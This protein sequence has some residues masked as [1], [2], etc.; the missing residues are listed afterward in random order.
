MVKEED[1]TIQK[2]RGSLSTAMTLVTGAGMAAAHSEIMTIGAGMAGGE[3]MII[4]A[5]TGG[6]EIMTIGVTLS[7]GLVIIA[8]GP[9]TIGTVTLRHADSIAPGTKAKQIIADCGLPICDCPVAARSKI[10]SLQSAMALPTRRE[11]N[12]SRL[13]SALVRPLMTPLNYS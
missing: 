7:I 11:E 12:A 8:A 2:N 3:I 4:G 13:E 5:G 6:G 9:I 1:R 10:D